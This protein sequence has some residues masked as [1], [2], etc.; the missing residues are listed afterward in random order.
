[1]QIYEG[2]GQAIIDKV[3]GEGA[4]SKISNSKLF[5][6]IKKALEYI[7]APMNLIVDIINKIKSGVSKL[8]PYTDKVLTVLKPALS[9]VSNLLSTIIRL[10]QKLPAQ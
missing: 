5:K 1:M 9:T 6:G 7:I 10:F 3:F 2:V 4:Y 8:S